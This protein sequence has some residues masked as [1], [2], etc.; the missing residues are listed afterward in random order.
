MAYTPVSKTGGVTPVRVQL[1][2][3]APSLRVNPKGSTTLCS[4]E[5]RREKII[6]G[7]L[8]LRSLPLFL[9]LPK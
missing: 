7:K 9:S 1:P 2:P 4:R 3:P 6:K 5:I 8:N